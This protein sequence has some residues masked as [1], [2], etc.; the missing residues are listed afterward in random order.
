M[1]AAGTVVRTVAMMVAMPVQASLV[2]AGKALAH[3]V[4]EGMAKAAAAAA[5]KVRAEEAQVAEEMEVE[6]LVG[7]AMG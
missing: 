5:M 7:V 6:T 1:A 4:M 2:A 3:V